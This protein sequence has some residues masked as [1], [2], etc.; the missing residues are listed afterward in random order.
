MV[1]TVI[2]LGYV[3]LTLSV[4]IAAAGHKVI[5]LDSNSLLV[6]Q[7]RG[8]NTHVPG[9]SQ[10]QL[11]SLIN[12]DKFTPTINPNLV[13]KSEVVIIAVPTPLDNHRKPDLSYLQ[14]A[15]ES[16]ANKIQD[17]ALIVNES[18]S[19][20]GT[21]RNFIKPLF[22]K[23]SSYVL[24]YASAPERV[25]PGNNE[26]NLENTPRVIAGLS[27]NATKSAVKFYSTFC[28]NIHTVPSPEV[29][30]AAKLFENTFRQINI[31][32]VNE[33]SNIASTLGFLASD[34]IKAAATKPFGFMPFFPS[35]GV[36]GH[37]IPVDPSYLSYIAEK[38]G[39]KANFINLANQTNLSMAKNI[40]FRIKDE[41]GGTLIDKYIQIAG[42]AYKS[43]V[44]DMRE[45][46]SLNLIRELKN[47]GA[48]TSWFDPLVASYNNEHSTPL[49]PNIDL[50]LIISPHEQIDFS[51][52]IS[53]GTKVF[54]LSA[55]SNNYGWPK[56]L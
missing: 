50:G 37:C 20:P 47:L 6:D 40:A 35:I 55:N 14:T 33:F 41:L 28:K 8:G 21:L 9:I 44:S 19:Y 2:G 53:A 51:T 31:A 56:F 34:A 10:S 13:S 48:K 27:E 29:A 12:Q 49:N 43:G 38:A 25:D 5:G 24:N 17:G 39:I 18:T 11:I 52:W 54:D 42:I 4:G 26:W 30:E 23:Y 15:I 22:E 46:P 3:G 36:G 1:V 45:S 16:V 32:L 7:L